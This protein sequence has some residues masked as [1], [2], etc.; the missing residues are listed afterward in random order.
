MALNLCILPK[1][2]GNI[3]NFILCLSLKVNHK[4]FFFLYLPFSLKYSHFS[5]SLLS[6]LC[7][8]YHHLSEVFIYIR[9][10]TSLQAWTLALSSPMSTWN[11]N[12]L[13]NVN[14]IMFNNLMQFGCLS[15]GLVI[16][17]EYFK[18][19]SRSFLL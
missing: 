16:N 17:W 12:H 2:S 18:R 7:V 1:T 3:F 6:L 8:G 10:L 4:C 9:A 19:L 11:P 15:N 5:S 14:L 13:Y